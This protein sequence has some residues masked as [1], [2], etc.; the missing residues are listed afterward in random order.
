MVNYWDLSDGEDITKT[1]ANFES[2]GAMQP[3]PNNT[4]VIAIIEEAKVDQDR[5]NNQYVSLR[6]SVL[7]PAEYKNRKVFHK[8]WCLDLRPA[9]EEV[10]RDN[11]KRMLFAIDTNAGG[12]VVASGRAPTDQTLSSFVGKQM[13]IKVMLWEQNGN[14]G[15]WV[16]SVSPKNGAAVASKPKPAPKADG[17]EDYI[18]F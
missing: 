1:G 16:A 4:T 14:S 18:P 7:S 15:N 13:Q 2:G 8:V 11:Q 3:I 6:W 9:K 5:E 12:K 10:Y 17:G